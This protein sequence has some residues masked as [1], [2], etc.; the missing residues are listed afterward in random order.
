MSEV[1]I[2][3]VVLVVGGF[4]V[5]ACLVAE[6][7][8]AEAYAAKRAAFYSECLTQKSKFDCDFMVSTMDET[9]AAPQF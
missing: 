5:W 2:A 7:K 9:R 1:L 4:L 6:R 3:A 8:D